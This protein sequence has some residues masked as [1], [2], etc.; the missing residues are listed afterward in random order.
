M[1]IL[2][3]IGIIIIGGGLYVLLTN[4]PKKEKKEKP[5]TKTPSA[6]SET[7]EEEEDEELAEGVINT[8]KLT[9]VGEKHW[10]LNPKSPFPLTVSP[11]DNDQA[12]ALKALLDLRYNTTSTEAVRKLLP[13][14]REYDIRCKEIDDYVKVF[15]PIFLKKMEEINT[16]SVTWE[17]ATPGPVYKELS[18]FVDKAIESLELQIHCNLEIL[19]R[20]HPKSKKTKEELIKK[21]GA[22]VMKIYSSMRK[23]INTVPYKPEIRKSLQR[24]EKL[25][26]LAYGANVNPKLLLKTLSLENMKKLVE[27]LN[28]PEF[29]NKEE[30]FDTISKLPDLTDRLQTVVK[31]KTIYQKLPIPPDHKEFTINDK[32]KE[33]YVKEF[34]TLISN[35]YYRGGIAI[36]EREEF[37]DKSYSFVKGWEIS[38]K[39]DACIFCKKQAEKTYGKEEYPRT[40]IHLGCRCTIMTA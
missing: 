18:E 16:T 38:A 6:S 21:Y 10:T 14:I 15:R 23:G 35:T 25:R 29:A 7:N 20:G 32:Q 37:Q 31:L 12:L 22:D 27:D 24:L 40:P 9:Q 39:K 36:A 8:G 5:E 33:E 17:G 26:L 13:F 19:F 30:A 28:Y 11:L 4:L 3:I 1:D 2:A 34:T